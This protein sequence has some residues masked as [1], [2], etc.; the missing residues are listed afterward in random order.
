MGDWPK[1]WIDGIHKEEGGV[2]HYG[3]RPQQG[4]EVMKDAMYG[5]ICNNSMWKARDDLTNVE[6]NVEDVKAA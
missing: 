1:D 6:L 5:L 2:H 4:V 3:V